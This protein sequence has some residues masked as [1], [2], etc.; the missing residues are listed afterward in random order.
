MPILLW[1]IYPLAIWSACAG[2]IGD[3]G[4]AGPDNASQDAQKSDR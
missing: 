4:K 3:D 1:V 2:I